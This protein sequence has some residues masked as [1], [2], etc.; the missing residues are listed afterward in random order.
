MMK[1]HFLM[2][3]LCRCCCF[4]PAMREAAREWTPYME[5][6]SIEPHAD[7]SSHSCATALTS[8]LHRTERTWKVLVAVDEQV[9]QTVHDMVCQLS[10]PMWWCLQQER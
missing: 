4:L 10:H 5:H 6:L 1:H 3:V 7:V 9:V 8:I 2:R